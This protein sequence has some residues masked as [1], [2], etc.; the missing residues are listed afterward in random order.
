MSELR[1]T[2]IIFTEEFT[3]Q[4]EPR[5]FSLRNHQFNLANP[6]QEKSRKIKKPSWPTD[7]VYVFSL[8]NFMNSE[9]WSAMVEMRR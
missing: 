7:S 4:E 3:D 8:A 5:G 9:S 6:E 1:R 2:Q